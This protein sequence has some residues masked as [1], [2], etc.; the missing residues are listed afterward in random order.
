MGLFINTLPLRLDIGD[1]DVV[2]AARQAHARLSG[3]LHHEHAPLALAQRCS[4][5]AAGMP[6][7]S[8]LLN[9][10]HNNGSELV[11]PEGMT[12]LSAQERTNYPFVLSVEDGGDSLGL[13][14]Q[15][16]E[17]VPAARI[18]GYMQQ[19]LASL[20]QALE[21]RP[22]LPASELEILPPSERRLL[23]EEWNQTA[24][25]YPAALCVHQLFER[26]AQRAPQAVAIVQGDR[27]IGYA[28]L[29]AQANRL[30]HA[31]IA[32][33]IQPGER[34][35]TRLARSIDLVA[36][37]LA[38]FKAGAVYV[39]IDPQLPAARQQW[40]LEDSGA[41]LI[42]GEA[43][44][45][46][47]LPLL[48][49]VVSGGDEND[50]A[51]SLSSGEVAYIMYTSGSTGLPKG[52]MTPH[53]GITR[54]V[55]NNRYAAFD[56]TERVAYA[57]N[58]AFDAATMEVWAALLNGGELV[59]IPA[60]TVM[61]AARLSAALTQHRVTT[62][63]LTTALFNQYVYSMGAT[64]AQLRY[65]ICGGE[66]EEPSAFERL[67][68]EAGPVQLIHAYGPTEATTFA[69]TAAIAEVQG[70]TRLP[71]GKPIGNTRAY[72]LDARG[73][74]AP[75]GAIGELYIG[76][77]G[78]ALGYLNRPELTAERFL[79]DPF[80]P[81][82]RMYRTGD[83]VRYRADGNLEYQRRNDRQVKIR[84]FRI[85]MGR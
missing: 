53:Q 13:T 72:V 34:V 42:V 85:E 70:A 12:L 81:G 39:P 82:G 59:V 84:G 54:L 27:R 49:P 55:L 63:F 60:E 14:A 16:S 64:L 37:Q 83:L 78:V 6:L 58:P 28:A 62:L 56:A 65:L 10:R 22:T 5:V 69:T 79:N 26:Q 35:A 36:T 8:A 17:P 75:L 33:G 30:A 18:C 50:P 4:G 25:P 71:I 47:T 77:V 74:P 43:A 51:L 24:E 67:L 11:L 38:I 48:R 23:L 9:Y 73:R 21:S 40:I 44:D 29:N 3:L 68:Q 7:F 1:D 80:N 52:V 76:G 45:G 2:T 57:A 41:R 20:A 15:V 19:A 46:D 61:D 66:K 32:H 31:L